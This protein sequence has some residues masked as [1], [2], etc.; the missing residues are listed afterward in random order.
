MSLQIESDI[1]QK[2]NNFQNIERELHNK[3][4]SA[5]STMSNEERNIIVNKIH[6]TA[7]LRMI[8]FDDLVKAYD[9]L[10]NNIDE[11]SKTLVDQI[12]ATKIAEE[13]LNDMKDNLKHLDSTDQNKVRMLQIN[14]Y[15]SERFRAISQFL[16]TLIYFILPIIIILVI[17]KMNLLPLQLTTIM[18]SITIFV[19]MLVLMYYYYDLLMRDNMNYDNIDWDKNWDPKNKSPTVYD[20]DMQQLGLEGKS[21]SDEDIYKSELKHMMKVMG[22]GCVGEECCSSGTTY[23]KKKKLCVDAHSSKV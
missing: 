8:M 12:E 18:I 17:Y 9:T 11:G 2:I 4:Q 20:Y 22:I 14:T 21:G 1:M 13:Q 15:Y 3:L 23:N 6:E 19:G 16:K 7:T 10:K 5:P